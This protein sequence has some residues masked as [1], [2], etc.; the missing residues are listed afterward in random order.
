MGLF[1]TMG[2]FL[3]LGPNRV[4]A[5]FEVLQDS[6]SI[7]IQI[8]SWKNLLGFEW[9]QTGKCILLKSILLN[10]SITLRRREIKGKG[11]KESQTKGLKKKELSHRRIYCLI[12][13]VSIRIPRLFKRFSGCIGIDKL[14]VHGVLG[15]TNPALTGQLHGLVQLLTPCQ[16]KRCE[17]LLTPY[18][19]GNKFEGKVTL[20]LRII[21][22]QLLWCIL[23]TGV[24]IFLITHK[25]KT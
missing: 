5:C 24:E 3:I 6:K 14:A 15:T 19:L 8:R 16:N 10:K 23:R 1:F 11:I 21:M 22:V 18:F 9:I 13:K 4:F 25:C 2:L 17:L 7:S 12:K 20:I